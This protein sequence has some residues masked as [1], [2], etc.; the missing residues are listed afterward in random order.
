MTTPLDEMRNLAAGQGNEVSEVR[1]IENRKSHTI[2][3]RKLTPQARWRARN[4]LATWCHAATASALKR[5]IIERQACQICGDERTDA[6]HPD[7]HF[8]LRILWRC[9]LHHKQAEKEL[10]LS[11][12]CEAAS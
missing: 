4:P 3:E 5:G 2:P 12:K 1:E 10:K 7:H 8:P 9:R 6:H 11:M